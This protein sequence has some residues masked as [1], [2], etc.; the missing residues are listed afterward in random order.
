MMPTALASGSIPPVAVGLPAWYAKII[1]SDNNRPHTGAAARN[2][3]I[4]LTEDPAFAGTIRFDRFRGQTMVGASLPWDPNTQIPR[5][6]ETG[7]DTR[8]MLWLQDH[9]VMVGS[10]RLVGEV[11]D[12]IAEANPY[13]PVIY[14]FQSLGWSRTSIWDS[15][16]RVGDGGS[17]SWLTR[18]LGAEDSSYVRAVGASWPI[19]AVE[20]IFTP[21]CRAPV[22]VLGGRTDADKSTVFKILGGPA[23]GSLSALAL[24]A[25]TERLQGSWVVEITDVDRLRRPADWKT[26]FDFAL[27]G[28]DRFRHRY[29]GGQDYK[30]PCAFG[31]TTERLGRTPELAGI[32]DWHF[33]Q[34]GT[35]DLDALA[36]DRD[37]FWAEV[38]VRYEARERDDQTV[39]RLGQFGEGADAVAT[40]QHYLVE[41][42]EVGSASLVEKNELHQD[43]NRWRATYGLHPVE[44]TVFGKNLKK[45]FP[46]LGLYR[47]D[48]R[49]LE[50]HRRQFYRGLRVIHGGRA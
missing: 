11:V 48:K 35:I 3:E 9:G 37:Q 23:Y 13:H 33:V 10:S 24:R 5:P 50:H 46:K 22:L 43:Y 47:P 28:V 29:R 30:R 41:R 34:C 36:R 1:I 8:A 26:L 2:A 19:M 44:K 39:P 27:R 42:C 6:W 32:P 21:G 45:A 16:P 14:F 12:V 18:Y 40:L 31:V 17:P 7:D 38:L 49:P 4:A 15:T 25:Q 20:R